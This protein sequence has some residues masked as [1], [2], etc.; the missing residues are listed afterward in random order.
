MTFD[1]P[2]LPYAKDALQ[3]HISVDTMTYHYD[4]HHKSYVDKLN[5]AIRDT[6]YEEKDLLEVVLES[7]DKGDDGVFNNAAQA[8][9]HDF[10]WQSMSPDTPEMD[11]AELTRLVEEFG[12]IDA[13]REAFVDAGTKQFGSGW[14]W[15]VLTAD[16]RLDVVGTPN[17]EPPQ[18][19]GMKPL[20]TCDLWE[21][22]Y[23]LDY[24]N[25]RGEFLGV[26]FDNLANWSFAAEQLRMQGEG[27]VVASRAFQKSQREFAKTGPVDEKA[28]EARD[29]LEKTRTG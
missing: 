5:T 9:N 26:F 8:W 24:Q 23:Y 18:I 28:R 13:L 6:E 3:P 11:D 20:L 1:L 12:G 4:K 17:A 15:V 10:F 21:H 14:V 7:H 22:A 16:G 19:H 25:E 2:E 29:D 27:N